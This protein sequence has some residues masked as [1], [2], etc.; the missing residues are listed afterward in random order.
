MRVGAGSGQCPAA[1]HAGLRGHGD[2]WVWWGGVHTQASQE[3][4]EGMPAF[5]DLLFTP[6]SLNSQF[7]ILLQFFLKAGDVF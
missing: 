5:R 7:S 1:E 3:L 6:E 2:P 4:P